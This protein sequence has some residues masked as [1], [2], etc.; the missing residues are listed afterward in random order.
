MPEDHDVRRYVA[1]LTEM[2]RR[3][4]PAAYRDFVRRWH[5][6]HQRGAAEKLVAMD[7][8]SLRA[9][10]ERMI[11]DTATLADLHESARAYLAEHGDAG[12][13]SEPTGGAE[14][15]PTGR[16]APLPTHRI[17]GAS[18]TLRLRKRPRSRQSEVPPGE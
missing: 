13:T 5:D 15:P 4:D 1:E 8:A 2:L 10:I 6:L 9:R 18:R 7:D 12:G 16:K 17:R 11:L 3:R 14:Q